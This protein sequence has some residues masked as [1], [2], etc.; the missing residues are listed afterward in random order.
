VF[1]AGG[2]GPYYNGGGGYRGGGGGGG[3]GSGGG[4]GNGQDGGN[5]NQQQGGDGQR[6]QAPSPAPTPPPT[7]PPGSNT[8]VINNNYVNVSGNNTTANLNKCAGPPLEQGGP[9]YVHLYGECCCCE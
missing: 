8:T 5:G 4:G 9:S 1:V 7:P 3:G 2:D 6:G